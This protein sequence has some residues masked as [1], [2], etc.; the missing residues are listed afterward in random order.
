MIFEQ[1]GS[2]LTL[3]A[4]ERPQTILELIR[5]LTDDGF[6]APFIKQ[7]RDPMIRAFWEKEWPSGGERE[8]GHR[9]RE[10]RPTWVGHGHLRWSPRSY[11][12]HGSRRR[13]AG[14]GA[15]AAAPAA[16]VRGPGRSRRRARGTAIAGAV[17]RRAPAALPVPSLIGSVR[18]MDP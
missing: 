2:T 8:R 1:A 16:A 14:P 18:S 12:R 5:I 13:R 3:F 6:R 4:D 9:G 10:Q 7:L 15:A 17:P 11:H